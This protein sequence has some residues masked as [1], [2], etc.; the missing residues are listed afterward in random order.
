MDREVKIETDISQTQSGIK[1]EMND[2]V[3]VSIVMD[4]YIRQQWSIFVFYIKKALS[5]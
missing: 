4:R 2:I 5:K 1:G 3:I